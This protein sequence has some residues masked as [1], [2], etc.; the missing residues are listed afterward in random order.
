MKGPLG[1]Q[2]GGIIILHP[3]TFKQVQEGLKSK[4]ATQDVVKP[5]AGGVASG[6]R[7]GYLR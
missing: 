3:Q 6:A 1:I 5:V 4:G 2:F 7:A